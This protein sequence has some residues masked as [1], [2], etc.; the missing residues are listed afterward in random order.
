MRT[1]LEY[2]HDRE[3][4]NRNQ[5]RETFLR[6]NAKKKIQVIIQ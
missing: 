4:K 6:K 1:D 2:N 5:T 3:D